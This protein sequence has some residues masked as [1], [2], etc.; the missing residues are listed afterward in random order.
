MIAGDGAGLG[1][2]IG[3]EERPGAGDP[4]VALDHAFVHFHA[5]ARSARHHQFAALD[6]EGLG[7]DFGG[8][9]KWVHAGA[10][11]GGVAGVLE[12][13]HHHLRPADA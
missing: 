6:F 9:R 2:R 11:G 13:F 5:E 10:A 7:Q 8:Q 1:G 4:G 12:P 3:A